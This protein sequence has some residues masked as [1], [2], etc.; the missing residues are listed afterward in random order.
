MSDNN[1]G[2]NPSPCLTPIQM[3]GN[4]VFSVGRILCTDSI[5]LQTAALADKNTQDVKI[6]RFLMGHYET[7]I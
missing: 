3:Y 1:H 5:H 6:E 4:V 2:Y 7:H